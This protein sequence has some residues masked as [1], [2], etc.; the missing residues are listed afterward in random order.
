LRSDRDRLLARA[1]R[2]ER[3]ARELEALRAHH[4]ESWEHSR[5]VARSCAELAHVLYASPAE[6]EALVLAGLGHDLGKLGIP[7]AVLDKPSGLAEDERTL[8]REHSERGYAMLERLD[9]HPARL[10]VLQHHCHVDDCYP[11]AARVSAVAGDGWAE[12]DVKLGSELAA[13]ISVVDM[14]DA[15]SHRRAYKEPQGPEHVETMVRGSYR[16]DPRFVEI[17]AATFLPS[18]EEDREG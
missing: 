7:G 2:D 14:F 16:G 17:V 6:R 11:D 12:S 18:A 5:R 15:L 1:L 4:A 13:V 3:L 10:A 8:I 9:H